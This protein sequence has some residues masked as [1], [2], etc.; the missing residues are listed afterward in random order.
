MLLLVGLLPAAMLAA[1]GVSRGTAAADV[2]MTQIWLPTCPTAPAL[3]LSQCLDAAA[4]N[5]ALDTIPPWC[6]SVIDQVQRSCYDLVADP[7][8]AAAMAERSCGEHWGD[9]LQKVNGP[10]EDTESGRFCWR[11]ARRLY[12]TRVQDDGTISASS[13]GQTCEQILQPKPQDQIFGTQTIASRLGAKAVVTTTPMW[14]TEPIIGPNGSDVFNPGDFQIGPPPSS[15]FYSLPGV[16]P[17]TTRCSQLSL[18]YTEHRYFPTASFTAPL[19]VSGINDCADYAIQ[20]YYDLAV[21]QRRNASDFADVPDILRV[22]AAFSPTQRGNLGYLA[23]TG[24]VLSRSYGK[25]SQFNFTANSGFPLSVGVSR[26]AHLLDEVLGGLKAQGNYYTADHRNR[27][28]FGNASLNGVVTPC[29]PADV[30]CGMYALI[31]ENWSWHK[32]Q[33]DKYVL[34]EVSAEEEELFKVKR[35]QFIELVAL[36]A[37]VELATGQRPVALNTLWVVPTDVAEQDKRMTALLAGEL[38][39]TLRTVSDSERRFIAE[40]FQRHLA[41]VTTL[42]AGYSAAQ[43]EE[44]LAALD[45]LIEQALLKEFARNPQV[46]PDR[47][48]LGDC[49]GPTRHALCDWLPEMFMDL[50]RSVREHDLL[51]L[52]DN[53]G[54]QRTTGMEADYQ[55]CLTYVG[56]LEFASLSSYEIKCP[57]GYPV[58]GKSQ[59][60]VC[61]C[62]PIDATHYKCGDVTNSSSN[63]YPVFYPATNYRAS[64]PAMERFMARSDALANSAFRVAKAFVPTCSAEPVM[65]EAY[66]DLHRIGEDWFGV[67]ANKTVEWSRHAVTGRST[68]RTTYDV[69]LNVIKPGLAELL[70]FDAQRESGGGVGPVSTAHV[71]V[72]GLDV[73]TAAN[74]ERSGPIDGFR[75]THSIPVGPVNVTIR[76]GVGGSWKAGTRVDIDG[77]SRPAECPNPGLC[78]KSWAELEAHA[79]VEGGVD[80]VVAAAGVGAQLQLIAF[81]PTFTANLGFSTADS[82]LH[83]ISTLAVDLDL[84]SGRFYLWVEAGPCPFCLRFTKTLWNWG[85]LHLHE[86]LWSRDIPIAQAELDELEGWSA[87]ADCPGAN[88]IIIPDPGDEP[89]I[90]PCGTKGCVVP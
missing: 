33:L 41:R 37:A 40:Q 21:F 9:C 75:G 52:V 8:N 3:T 48:K 22:K 66:S 29:Q 15:P 62:R 82:K 45:L 12:P 14:G 13:V 23:T 84:L 4:V 85:G 24:S 47:I 61:G 68:A 71:K 31:T 43:L 35:L 81:K 49:L 5:A 79:F 83:L 72:L 59:F 30:Y 2:G 80:V 69:K 74:V 1:A 32:R 58:N 7:G 38:R 90:P 63:T 87:P 34:Q 76:Y 18:P 20:K 26:R 60:V 17:W 53:T 50:F 27:V 57:V 39:T 51:R 10:C 65:Q 64:V 86:T 77:G 46:Q 67:D 6:P 44:R 19:P 42:Y 54:D 11:I 73:I 78:L 16:S 25:E 70:H 56:T 89:V 88:I 55:R 36:R 28:I